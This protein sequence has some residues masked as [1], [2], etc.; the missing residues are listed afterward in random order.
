[1]N[2][3]TELIEVWASKSVIVSFDGRVVEVF[4]FA[5]AQRFHVGFR[6]KLHFVGKTR[7]SIRPEG[8]GGNYTFFYAPE[9]RPALET[10]V[11]RVN[12]A[13]DKI[14]GRASSLDDQPG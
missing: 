1:M 3:S 9:C 13:I 5:D 4:G 7:L 2:E 8:G 10:F 14:A 11:E 12:A 6:P